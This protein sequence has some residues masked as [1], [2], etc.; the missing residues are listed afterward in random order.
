MNRSSENIYI[1][2]L[3]SIATFLAALVGNELFGNS[4]FDFMTIFSLWLSYWFFVTG[5][6]LFL[7]ICKKVYL[8]LCNPLTEKQITQL[9]TK[10]RRKSIDKYYYYSN[11]YTPFPLD[12]KKNMNPK[13]SFYNVNIM[14]IEL[15]YFVANLLKYKKHEWIVI[16]FEKNHTVDMIWVNKG[17]DKSSATFKISNELVIEIARENSIE[18]VFFFHNHPNSDPSKF[19]KTSPSETDLNTAR[20]QTNLYMNNKLNLLEYVCERGV[21]HIYWKSINDD[22]M[23]LMGFTNH[24]RDF[25]NNISKSKNFSLNLERIF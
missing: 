6:I 23:P 25:E 2:I 3:I 1:Y 22:F 14:L 13:G 5:V 21:P 8:Y 24:I 7:I 20:I 10:R 15:P 19:S 16:A 18:S 11:S 17:Q 4:E 9:A 12:F